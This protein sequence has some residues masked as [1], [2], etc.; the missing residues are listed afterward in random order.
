MS[1]LLEIARHYALADAAFEATET[2]AFENNDDTAYDNARLARD[3]NDQAWF[4]YLFTR[5]EEK[6]NHSSR[7]L[8]TTRLQTAPDWS[9]RRI[10]QAWSRIDI[11]DI[12]FLSKVEVLTDKSKHDYATIKTCYEGRNTIAHGGEWEVEFFVPNVAQTMNDVSQR[13]VT[14]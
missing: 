9:E 4:L 10:W 8:L 7:S 6:V 11:P 1:A 3:R 5:F 12:A 14:N 2:E 13:L